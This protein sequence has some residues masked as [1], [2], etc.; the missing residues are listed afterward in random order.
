MALKPNSAAYDL[1]LDDTLQELLGT[2]TSR[3]IEIEDICDVATLPEEAAP[4]PVSEINALDDSVEIELS[5]DEVMSM[6]GGAVG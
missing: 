3:A 1:S 2:R 4:L 5:A 6:L